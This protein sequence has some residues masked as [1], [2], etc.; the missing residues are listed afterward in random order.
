MDDE[1]SSA[2]APK[3]GDKRSGNQWPDKRDKARC[4]E[5]EADGGCADPGWIDFG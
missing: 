3:V 4:I 1:G 2:V 5:A